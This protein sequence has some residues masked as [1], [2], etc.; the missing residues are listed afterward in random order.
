M[1]CRFDYNE[2][3]SRVK[4]NAPVTINLVEGCAGGATGCYLMR[5]HSTR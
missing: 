1:V 5:L 4:R 3:R 2:L